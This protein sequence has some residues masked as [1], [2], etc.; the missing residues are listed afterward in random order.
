[1]LLQEK[2][3]AG[4]KQEASHAEHAIVEQRGELMYV[5]AARRWQQRRGW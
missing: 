5:E 1:M 3:F 2:H 4:G